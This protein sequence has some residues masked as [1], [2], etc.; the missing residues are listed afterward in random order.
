VPGRVLLSGSQQQQ[1]SGQGTIRRVA[2]GAT[3]QLQTLAGS[4]CGGPIR[5]S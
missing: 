4:L 2:Q 5:P 3:L 1:F